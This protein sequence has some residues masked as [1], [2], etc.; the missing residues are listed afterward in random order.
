MLNDGPLR[1]ITQGQEISSDIDEKAL[2]DFGFK[3]L[4]LVFVSQ[5]APSR[6]RF[7]ESPFRPKTVRMNF[8]PQICTNFQPKP[9]DI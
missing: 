1:L 6:N 3:D 7:D 2:I 8:H 9:S 4:Q 5:G